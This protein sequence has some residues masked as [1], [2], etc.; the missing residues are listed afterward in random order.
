MG[1][2]THVFPTGDGI[3]I[4]TQGRTLTNCL[5]LDVQSGWAI[6][7]PN[8]AIHASFPVGFRFTVDEG[9]EYQFIE[10]WRGTIFLMSLFPW[11]CHGKDSAHPY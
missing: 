3:K 8:L 9:I 5:T 1:V 6:P 10:T 4:W 11:A 2:P 7:L